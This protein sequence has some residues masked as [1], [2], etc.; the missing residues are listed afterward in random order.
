M[1]LVWQFLFLAP[2]LPGTL[3]L[4]HARSTDSSGVLRARI[5]N[6]GLTQIL[7]LFPITTPPLSRMKIPDVA[8]TEQLQGTT[9][10]EKYYYA[11]SYK[12]NRSSCG[13]S[14]FSY[15]RLQ[16]LSCMPRAQIVPRR[17]ASE[18]PAS[19]LPG[20]RSSFP[21]QGRILRVLSLLI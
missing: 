18:S 15:C 8:S 11:D 16:S 7:F 21:S 20:S 6:L 13:V 4:L 10:G 5:T 2:E 1:L 9:I 12:R 19:A 14:W 17:S 3:R